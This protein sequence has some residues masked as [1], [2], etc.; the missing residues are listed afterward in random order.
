M[1]T[2]IGIATGRET[3]KNRGVGPNV[4]LLQVQFTDETDV[5]TVQL[6]GQA[7]EESS[8]PNGSLIVAQA[9]G[10]AY[11]VAV[12]TD[13]GVEPVLEI[14]GKRIYSVDTNVEVI[15]EIRLDPD[16]TVTETTP[17]TQRVVQPDGT[18]TE[19][20]QKVSVVMQPD[21]TLT[22]TN[23][24]ATIT[25]S[26]AGVV[27]IDAPTVHMTGDLDVDGTITAPTVVGTADVVF[28]GKSSIAHVH[29]GI[30][31]GI[32]NTEPPV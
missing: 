17:N 25:V 15:A 5:Q 4:R 9:G 20:N 18:I 28:G 23:P 11:K 3:A 21:G 13:D 8:P 6:V 16:G 32:K 7:G 30:Q 24:G 19:A 22:V 12:G 10:Q 27:T 31:I 26:P 29:G 1:G 2:R 14:G